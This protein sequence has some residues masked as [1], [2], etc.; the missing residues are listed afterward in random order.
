MFS[1]S[2]GPEGRQKQNREYCSLLTCHTERLARWNGEE[3]GKGVN[4]YFKS[5]RTPLGYSFCSMLAGL[6][7]FILCILEQLG[8]LICTAQL[9]HCKHS[10]NLHNTPHVLCL[11]K[12]LGI[13]FRSQCQPVRALGVQ[14]RDFACFSHVWKNDFLPRC[15][16]VLPQG[17]S[18]VSH[19]G[20]G[21]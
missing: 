7:P 9:T 17:A 5:L 1:L 14:S 11:S 3:T 8:L 15:L 16:Y 18:H 4:V 13:N 6:V 20:Q 19:T 2:K 10:L 21:K 12:S